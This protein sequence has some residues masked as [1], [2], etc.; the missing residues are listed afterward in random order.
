MRMTD[1][2]AYVWA[3]ILEYQYV[4]NLAPRKKGFGST[5]PDVDY[6]ANLFAAKRSECAVVIGRI[7]HDF[8]SPTSGSPQRR[9]ASETGEHNTISRRQCR[10][11]V[12]KGLHGVWLTR[13]NPADAKRAVGR[14]KIR[15]SLTIPCDGDPFASQTIEPE[16]RFAFPSSVCRV[17][18]ELC[19][20]PRTAPTVL[21]LVRDFWNRPNT[22]KSGRV[23]INAPAS[24]IS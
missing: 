17:V 9:F 4:L 18:E 16:L 23:T 6:A 19:H 21:P 24:R 3:A 8:R 20:Y 1:G 14:R 13:L 7:E 10:P 2:R 22:S 15:S 5:G 12:G 11:P